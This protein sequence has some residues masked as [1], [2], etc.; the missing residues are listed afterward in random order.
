MYLCESI[1]KAQKHH[2][3]PSLH[4]TETWRWC[5]LFSKSLRKFEPSQR[6]L[7]YICRLGNSIW[8][9][10][11]YSIWLKKKK[12]DDVCIFFLP[13]RVLFNLCFCSLFHFFGFCII[14]LVMS[15]D[16][17][18]HLCVCI[19]ITTILLLYARWCWILWYLNVYRVFYLYVTN[20]LND[21]FL[22]KGW[23]FF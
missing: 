6:V 14:C 15:F 23:F 3:K 11:I 1:K 18:L 17:S 21:K 10:G 16:W 12:E 7:L 2:M 13:L 8:S 5:W 19:L 9:F 4:N 22:Q 20:K